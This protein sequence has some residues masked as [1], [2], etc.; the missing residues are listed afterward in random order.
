MIQ[1]FEP[2]PPAKK[3]YSPAD[4]LAS[5]LRVDPLLV[6][7]VWKASVAKGVD[8]LLAVALV[9]HETAHT[10]NPSIVGVDPN[11]YGL[12]QLNAKSH[13]QYKDDI[14]AHINE[15]LNYLK[16]NLTRYGL[17]DGLASYNAGHPT[18]KG[19][20]YANDKVLPIYKEL[21]GQMDQLWSGLTQ[22]ELNF[23]SV[24]EVNK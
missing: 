24:K 19:R 11:D 3:Q 20:I 14:D 13:P 16:Q 10:W 23:N 1:N 9:T 4:Y 22:Q 2:K 17:I 21:R 15:G 6:N 5:K 8:P 18:D 7:K 12:F